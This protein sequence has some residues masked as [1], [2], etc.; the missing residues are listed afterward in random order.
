MQLTEH[1]DGEIRGSKIPDMT[2]ATQDGVTYNVW[3]GVESAART[4]A[5]ASLV[6]LGNAPLIAAFDRHLPA[7][8]PPGWGGAD[9][10][11]RDRVHP[12]EEEEDVEDE[13]EPDPGKPYRPRW[14]RAQTLYGLVTVTSGQPYVGKSSLLWAR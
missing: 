2:E 12:E 5:R 9:G 6:A 1:V 14:V 13:D 4:A 3:V 11:G 7:E 8:P 10:D